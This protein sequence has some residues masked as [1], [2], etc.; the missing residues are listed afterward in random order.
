MKSKTQ[1]LIHIGL[2]GY[3]M[4]DKEVKKAGSSGRIY[5]PIRWI[6]KRVKVILL[7]K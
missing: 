2:D 4:L 1:K 3:E 7:E 6:N 5:L